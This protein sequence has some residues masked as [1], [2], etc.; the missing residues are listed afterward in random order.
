MF[1]KASPHAQDGKQGLGYRNADDGQY[2]TAGQSRSA[3]KTPSASHKKYDFEGSGDP[4]LAVYELNKRR[5]RAFEDKLR[6][7]SVDSMRKLDRVQ[8]LDAA[9]AALSRALY[10][11][12][13]DAKGASTL[14]STSNWA[15]DPNYPL[16]REINTALIDAG[17]TKPGLSSGKGLTNSPG[18][19]LNGGLN[20][21]T[22]KADI[23]AMLAKLKGMS[24][25]ESSESNIAM[26]DLNKLTSDLTTATTMASTVQKKDADMKRS[27][28]DAL[29]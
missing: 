17:M 5:M 26:V 21:S 29:R 1:L 7:H 11:F 12:P 24:Q 18:G 4:M 28:I 22:T 2:G 25:R 15:K 13:A 9:T 19:D 10:L 14:G 6:S 23:D 8:L 27:I 3:R 16:E 20:G